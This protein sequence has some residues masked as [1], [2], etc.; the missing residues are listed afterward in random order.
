MIYYEII[1][2]LS[3]AKKY[4]NI[5]ISINMDIFLK[6]GEMFRK[7]MESVSESFHNPYKKIAALQ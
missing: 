1:N 3:N 2:F 7:A 4:P 5:N 6:V